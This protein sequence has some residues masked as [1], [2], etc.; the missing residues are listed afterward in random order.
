LTKKDVESTE[1]A[2]YLIERAMRKVGVF[3]NIVNVDY[4][5]HFVSFVDTKLG[6]L[7]EDELNAYGKQFETSEE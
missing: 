1:Q 4:Y 5:G 6:N 7:T 3:E 2:L